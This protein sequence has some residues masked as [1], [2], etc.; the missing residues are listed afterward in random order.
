MSIIETALT[1]VVTAPLAGRGR[2]LVA[3]VIDSVIVLAGSVLE[4]ILRGAGQP[5]TG[6]MLGGL[7]MLAVVL[8][9][10]WLLAVRGQSIGKILLKMAI[11]DL[12]TKLPPGFLRASVIRQGVQAILAQ[13]YPVALLGFMT[14]DSL[15][16]FTSSRRCLHDRF[17]RTEV[18]TVGRDWR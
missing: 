9:Q 4:G 16:I 18:I 13:L 11:V 6:K 10:V 14:V 2:R 12:D 3:F 7:W 17:A 8:V 1:E 5:S 15:L